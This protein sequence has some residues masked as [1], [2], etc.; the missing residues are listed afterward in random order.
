MFCV[1]LNP[2]QS[3]EAARKSLIIPDKIC[4]NPIIRVIRVPTKY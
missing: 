1:I 2:L 3:L 4:A